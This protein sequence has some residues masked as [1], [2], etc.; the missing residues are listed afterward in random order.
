[1]AVRTH[2]N[3]QRC[4]SPQRTRRN[5]SSSRILGLPRRCGWDRSLDTNQELILCA[6][7]YSQGSLLLASLRPQPQ[8]WQPPQLIGTACKERSGAILVTAS[9]L[10][11]VS[12]W[13]V[14]LVQMHT[15]VSIRDMRL[16]TRGKATRRTIEV[17]TRA[18]ARRG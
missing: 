4:L 7:F 14:R 13:Q 8:V 1:M 9:S 2:I 12:A 17:S 6:K 5:D 16:R 10:P 18:S 15:A 3:Q 11:I